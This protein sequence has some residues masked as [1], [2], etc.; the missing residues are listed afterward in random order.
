MGNARDGANTEY[1]W[2][3]SAPAHNHGY[4]GP[5]L[6]RVL[7]PPQGR[8][9]LDLGCG[10]GSLTSKFSAA[11]FSTVG[12]EAAA[13]GVEQAAIAFPEVEFRAQDIGEPLPD[14]WRGSF[15]VVV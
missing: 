13:S 14:E 12:A 3:T 7:G 10:N 15:D 8:R 5:A 11:G 6:L 2:G 1:V 9:L 4:L